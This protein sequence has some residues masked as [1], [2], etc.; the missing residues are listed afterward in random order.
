[1]NH[2]FNKNVLAHPAFKQTLHDILPGLAKQI[3]L[4]YQ[5]K[6]LPLQ[7]EIKKQRI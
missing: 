2:T 1:L 4:L 6:V 7:T 3:F 5:K